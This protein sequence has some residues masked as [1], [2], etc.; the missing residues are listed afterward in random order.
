MATVRNLRNLILSG[1]DDT[2][3]D[4]VCAYLTNEKAV[5]GSRMFPFRFYTA[6]DVL[7][8]L[9]IFAETKLNPPKRVH[10]Q[11][12]ALKRNKAFQAIKKKQ[13]QMNKGAIH[14]FYEALESAIA[15]SAKRNVPPIK[16]STLLICATGLEVRDNNVAKKVSNET[17]N[18]LT[19]SLL[20]TLM[21]AEAAEE[22][23]VMTYDSRTVKQRTFGDR[24]K[25]ILATV[26]NLR[27]LIA[28]MPSVESSVDN[29]IKTALMSLIRQQVS[30]DT[31]ILVHGSQQ[32]GDCNMMH[33]W[34]KQ[35]RH[36]V[37]PDMVYADIN[38]QSSES[39]E[40]EIDMKNI[41]M[42]GFSEAIFH[43]LAKVSYECIM[44]INRASTLISFP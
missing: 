17:S 9:D 43:V 11:K 22:V 5:A 29:L 10:D 1:I 28:N 13:N 14:R 41:Y 15:I 36:L 44:T 8:E 24:D 34:L 16:G 2:H 6:F 25:S 23:K 42:A 19:V 26:K 32:P 3:V 20:F 39:L 7:T 18:A 31:I 30:Y 27:E 12:E 21:A 35:Y 37:N 40:S 33:N 38:V 4:K